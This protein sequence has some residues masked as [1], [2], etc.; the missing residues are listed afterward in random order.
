MTQTPPPHPPSK[1]SP[2]AHM[3]GIAPYARTAS[4]VNADRAL[5]A[6][7]TQLRIAA[8]RDGLQPTAVICEV[9]SSDVGDWA[10]Q[11]LMTMD[12][13]F[14]VDV[15]R[16]TRLGVHAVLRLLRAGVDIRSCGYAPRPDPV[17]LRLASRLDS[18]IGA[19]AREQMAERMRHGKELARQRRQGMQQ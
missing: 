16:L 2:A 4:A 19:R 10:Q 12:V 13:V 3:P 18:I 17:A 9:T 5:G 6:Q 7:V 8:G 15:D 1:A 11:A 14:I